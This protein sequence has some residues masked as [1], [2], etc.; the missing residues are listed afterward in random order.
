MPGYYG[1]IVIGGLLIAMALLR[2]LYGKPS[3]R[4]SWYEELATYG[5]LLLFVV[6]FSLTV[7]RSPEGMERF[8][9]DI[10][11]TIPY[12]SEH[13]PLTPS[14]VTVQLSSTPLPDQKKPR[15][16]CST[17]HAPKAYLLPQL[18]T[19]IAADTLALEKA[20]NSQ[21]A[22]DEKTLRDNTEVNR[23]LPK[24]DTVQS[25]WAKL[26]GWV[27]SEGRAKRKMQQQ[28]EARLLE[29]NQIKSR[30]QEIKGHY[31]SS[32]FKENSENRM[33]EYRTA[34]YSKQITVAVHRLL[35]AAGAN[36]LFYQSLEKG[37]DERN[38]AAWSIRILNWGALL[39]VMLVLAARL[40]IRRRF[41]DAAWY[42]YPGMVLF[43]G[44]SLQLM[45]DL[46]LNY[47]DKLR[48]IAFYHWRNTFLSVTAFFAVTQAL[49]LVITR[50]FIIGI[51]EFAR[52]KSFK[53]TII[54]CMFA[55][56]AGLIGYCMPGDRYKITELIKLL[57]LSLLAWYA[58][59]RADYISRK[60][61]LSGFKGE[62][63]I[64]NNLLEFLMISLV[65]MLS[66]LIIHD[67]GPLLVILVFIS[68]Y[69]WLLMGRR[70]LFLLLSSWGL[71][72]SAGFS[73]RSWLIKVGPI[74]HIYRRFDE[75]A[76]PFLHGTGELAKLQWLRHSA[77]W[78]GYDF[79]EVT[80]S[81][82][83][84]RQTGKMIVSPAQL[85]SDYTI[86]HLIAVWGYI[87]GFLLLA[88]YAAWL[89][90]IFISGA[91]SAASIQQSQVNRLFGW[92]LTLAALMI[93]IQGLLT[94]SGNFTI[95]PLSG[96]TFPMLSYGSAT[97]LF[98]VL[99]ISVSYAK[100]KLQ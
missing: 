41:P 68:I 7:A 84:I 43:M 47:L 23:H 24:M 29:N 58:M 67:F 70:M 90:A 91:K 27:T 16:N 88:L 64:T 2:G 54:A 48:F 18:A 81:G 79:G 89:L 71:L 51:V 49:G 44:V 65:T 8:R 93:A 22:E 95:V 13:A 69:T 52:L 82:H 60:T 45:T 21:L 59:S 97:L 34:M 31:Q 30:L 61:E 5:A 20:F 25:V 28:S 12:S 1:L 66:F 32:V 74:A 87:P 86:T 85:Q 99:M 55:L 35:L 33:K 17:C 10:R 92:W 50:R 56:T 75:M 40:L 14:K 53:T 9:N 76:A 83:Y 42:I 39:F 72:I 11:K 37:N 96:L 36:D 38:K 4:N 62:W 46:S 19:T 77:G 94:F 98:S 63:W 26:T 80:Y 78:F 73:L 57:L 15:V 6:A 100:E 3:A